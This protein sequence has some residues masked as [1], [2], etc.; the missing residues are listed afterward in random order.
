MID[1]KIVIHA[2]DR[3]VSAMVK[4]LAFE[5][6]GPKSVGGATKEF[7]EQHGYLVFHFQSN[8]KAQEFREA[9]SLYLPGFLARTEKG[10]ADGT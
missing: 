3:K 10:A 1:V 4:A 9:L 8:A 7:L 6:D 5:V 2:N